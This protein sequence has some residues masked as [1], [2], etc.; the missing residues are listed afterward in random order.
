[1]K[2]KIKMWRKKENE[3]EKTDKRREMKKRERQQSRVEYDDT[4]KGRQQR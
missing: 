2:K 4:V 3:Q 1:M